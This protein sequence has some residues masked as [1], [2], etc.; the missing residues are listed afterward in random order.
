MWMFRVLVFVVLFFYTASIAIAENE[1]PLV[2]ATSTGLHPFMGKDINGKPSGMLVDLWKLWAEKANR[3]IEFRIYNWQESIEA[4]KN[5]EAD[6]HAGMFE[7]QERGKVIAFSGPIYDVSSSFY[8]RANSAINKIPSDGSSFILG[9]LS[10]SS[11]EERSASLYP[12]LKLASFQ[13]PQEL[14][15]ALL[16]STV[17]IVTAEDGSFIHMT[18][19]Y[20]A[21]GKIKRLEVDRWVDDIH[22]GVLKTRA[23]LLNLVEQGLRAISASDYSALEKRWLD[24]DVRVAFRSNGKPLSLTDSEKNWLSKQ[25]KITVGIMENWV[26]FSFQSETG[27]RVGISAS[28]FNIINKLLGNKLVLRPGEWKTLLNDVKDGKIDAVLDIT[29]LPKRE[30]FYHFTTPYLETR[31]AIFGRKT[32]GGAFAY[33]DVST[34]TIALERGFGNVQFY[35][36]LYPDIKIIEVDDTLAALQFVAKGKAQ[37][38]IGN[39]IAGMFAAN[40]GGIENLVTPIIAEDRASIPLNIGVRKDARILRDIFQ[41]AIETITPEQMDNIITSS[42]GGNSSSVFAITDEERAWLNTKP[43]ARIFIGSW[44]PYFYMENGQPKGL[45]YEYVRHIL[46][47]LGVD[48]DTRH[49]TWAEGIENI[50]SLQAVD[51]LPTAAFSEERAKYLNFTPD[52]TSSPMVIVSRKNSSVITD[53]DDLKGMTI[54]VEN[55]F[56]MHQRLRA[57]RPDLNLATYPT[58]TKALEAVSLGQ[59]DAYVGNLAAAGYLIE[60]QG[61]GNLK[62]AA[63]TGYDVNSWGIAIR[64]DWP[65]LTSLMSKYLAQM[66]DEEHSQLRKAALTV[67]F[68]HGIDWKTVIYWVTGLAIVLGSV[69]AVIVY[70]NRRLG[71][72]VQERKKAQFELTGALDTISQSIDYA[73][74]IQKAI[75]P[76]DAFLKEDL[77]DHFVIWEPRDVVGGDLYWYRRCEGGFILVLADCTGHG[78]PGAF[79][80]M[81]ATGALDRAL[82]EQK[83]GD[84]AILLSYMHRS[85][86]Y[87]L[88]QDQ[89]DGASDDGLELGICKI[90]ADTGDLTF[91]GARFSLFKV[92]EQECEEIKGDKKGIGYRGIAS[93]QTFT[94]Q[95]VVT[96][97]DAT[98]VMTSDGITDQIGGERRRGFGKKRLKKLLLSAQG[99]KLEK[100]KGLILDAF[101]EH[102]G[103]EQRRD[104]VSMIGFKVR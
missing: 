59:A 103:D 6:I 46:T 99:Y 77:K 102:Q 51:I 71:S 1:K 38:Y 100:Q 40:K 78:V 69:I 36:D 7:G 25:G 93:D 30:P 63:P 17:D 45:G 21:K 49:M 34:A 79:M 68:E 66:S 18:S 104:D 27:Q 15:K 61:F 62:I 37:Y 9:V 5:G 3:K 55:E 54:S 23:D 72:E 95:P 43:K 11:H 35:R 48:Y 52:Y 98:F 89:K 12:H 47:A 76:N 94:N 22:V 14:V 31:H 101:N 70:W 83:N 39:R 88:G 60:K 19:V 90:E 42:V 85:I 10:G 29:P 58:T 64:K 92:T 74:N 75:L 57:E 8:V 96:D 65:E 33:P 44:Q 13:T 84:P 26:P 16:D 97:I 24:Q 50:K 82:R 86:Q 56:I 32:K 81:L 73:S 41:K 20:G 91:A 80:T 87:S 53:L 2:I 28:V 67:R 4:I